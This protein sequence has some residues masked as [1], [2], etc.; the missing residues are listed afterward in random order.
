MQSAQKPGGPLE[1]PT[2]PGEITGVQVPGGTLAV[3]QFRS[4]TEP[5]LAIHGISSQA[6]DGEA[7]P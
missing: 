7:R 5:V 1:V 2:P 6:L 3:E 4:G